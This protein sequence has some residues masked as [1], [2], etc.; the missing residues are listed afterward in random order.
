MI[1]QFYFYLQRLTNT[2]KY[3]QILTIDAYLLD[4]AVALEANFVFE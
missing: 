1:L 4:V 3:L 2:Y